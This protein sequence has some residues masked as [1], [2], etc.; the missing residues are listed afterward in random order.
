MQ[1]KNKNVN[2]KLQ[3]FCSN[4][5]VQKIYLKVNHNLQNSLDLVRE[6]D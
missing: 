3:F 4:K 2:P 6:S 5:I 1:N